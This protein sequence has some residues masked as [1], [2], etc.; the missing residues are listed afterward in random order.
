MTSNCAAEIL[1]LIQ[2]ERPVLAIDED[3]ID[4]ELSQNV[5]HPW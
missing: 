5:D 4:V 1:E 3:V 2:A